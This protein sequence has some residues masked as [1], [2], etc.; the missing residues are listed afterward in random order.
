MKIYIVKYEDYDGSDSAGY[1]TEY[2]KAELCCT[3]LNKACPSYYIKDAWDIEEFDL[4][5]TDYTS[6][7]QEFDAKE[8]ARKENELEALKQKKMDEI[9]RLNLELELLNKQIKT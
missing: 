4:D 9:K 5:E 3:Y 6:L 8:R 1:F 2:E 7:I